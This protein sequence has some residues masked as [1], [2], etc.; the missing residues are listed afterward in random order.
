MEVDVEGERFRVEVRREGEG[1]RAVVNGRDVRVD[2]RRVG[3]RTSMLLWPA[4]G[5]GPHASD[6]TRSRAP[7]SYDVAVERRGGGDF[8][9]HLPAQ[10]LAVAVPHLV[11]GRRTASGGSGSRGEAAMTVTAPM[12][13]RIVKVLVA[14]GEAV[15]MRQPLVV[16][17]AMKMENELRAPADGVVMEVRAREGTLVEAR[18]VLVVLGL[19]GDAMARQAEEP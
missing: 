7:A 15:R 16:V 19:P 13:G 4:G 8:L 2:A 9:V 1:W 3:V 6:E 10:A 18:A 5:E 11:R 12:P 14:P 17:E